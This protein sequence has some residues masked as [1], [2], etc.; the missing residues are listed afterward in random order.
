V[1]SK[2]QG[3]TSDFWPLLGQVWAITY[4]ILSVTSHF[5]DWW[6]RISD[7]EDPTGAIVGILLVGG[8]QG[9]LGGHLW[10]KL[11]SKFGVK[12]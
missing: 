2:R 3:H 12:K 7:R 6:S 4:A 10:N 5:L 1:F 8:F 11:N 9:A